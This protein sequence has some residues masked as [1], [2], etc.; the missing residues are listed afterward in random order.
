MKFKDLAWRTMTGF[1]LGEVEA[2]AAQVHPS[3]HESAE[4]LA[5]KQRLY[6]HGA[7]LLEIGDRAAGYVLS[8]P[9]LFGAPPAL[10]ALLGA[11]PE[12]ADTYYIHDLAILPLARRIGA[13]SQIVAA[14]EKHARVRGLPTMSLV[15][16][17]GSISFWTKQGFAPLEL[18]D[19]GHKLADYG[20]EARMMAKPLT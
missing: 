18:P 12:R 10:N 20:P 9:W 17:T 2:I 7:Y 4:V 16:V 5:E 13:A 6:P 11:L 14:L 8:H 15:T 19:I 3:L 1:D